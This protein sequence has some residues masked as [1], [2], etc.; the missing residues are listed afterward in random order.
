MSFM[1]KACNFAE[2]E[3]F[4]LNTLFVFLA[5]LIVSRTSLQTVVCEALLVIT[6]A[7]NKQSITDAL[8]YRF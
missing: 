6:S 1:L 2:G 7:G 8:Q 3:H 5:I 4:V